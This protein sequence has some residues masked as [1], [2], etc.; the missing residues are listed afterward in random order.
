[1]CCRIIPLPVKCGELLFKSTTSECFKSFVSADT[2]V[3]SMLFN[4][5]LKVPDNLSERQL[6]QRSRSTAANPFTV[7]AKIA[8]E[9]KANEK[10]EARWAPL[11][12]T[13]EKVDSASVAATTGK[14]AKK[15]K[16]GCNP[17]SSVHCCCI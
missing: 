5:E 11:I 3:M 16:V 17:F 2:V 14:Y 8:K 15:K 9:K 13:F 6:K 12:E 10:T 7:K 4:K 1:M